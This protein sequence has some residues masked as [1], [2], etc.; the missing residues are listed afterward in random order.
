MQADK[1]YLSSHR[2][3]M[4]ERCGEQYRRRYV[5]GEKI[6]PGI[7]M[8]RGTGVHGGAK[9]NFRQKIDTRED[10]PPKDIVDISVTEFERAFNRDGVLLTPEEETV[11]LSNVIGKGKDSVARL[12]EV[13]ATHIAPK[14]QPIM[15]EETSRLIIDGSPYDLLAVMDMA[16]EADRVVDLKTAL[17]A[18]NQ[19]EVDESEQLTFYSLVFRAKKGKLPSEVVLETIIDSAPPKAKSL[20]GTRTD[21]DLVTLVERINVMIDG[22]N[23]GVFIPAQPTSWFCDPRYCGYYMTCKYV[24]RK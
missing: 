3:Q 4:Y 19:R 20:V 22:L 7:A 11:G 18:K 2:L 12:S 1:P 23:K 9:A 16:D 21:A 14:Y 6:P 10:L 13:F 24:R 8:L 15:V 17:K 5:L